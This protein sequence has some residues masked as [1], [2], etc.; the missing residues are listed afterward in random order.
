[1]PSGAGQ[2]SLLISFIIQARWPRPQ[3]LPRSMEYWT[4]SSGLS[5]QYIQPRNEAWRN[6]IATSELFPSSS[7]DCR[8]QS[9]SCSMA[10]PRSL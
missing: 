6:R 5:R 7:H 2:T 10:V 1:M 9:A 3:M 4:Q 8:A